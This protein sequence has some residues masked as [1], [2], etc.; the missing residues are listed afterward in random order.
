V[1]RLA[2]A[3]KAHIPREQWV[4]LRYE[5]IFSRP[6]EMFENA[7]EQIGIDFTPEIERNCARLQPTSIVRGKPQKE[8]WKQNNPDAIERI[9]PAIAGLQ[10]ELGYTT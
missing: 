1:A 7:F 4:H 5:D 10:A 2:L 9:L 3:A 6:V 8:K